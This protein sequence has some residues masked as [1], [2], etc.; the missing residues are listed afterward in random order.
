MYT[1]T[2]TQ[3]QIQTH[4][5][6]THVYTCIQAHT[7]TLCTHTHTLHNETYTHVTHPCSE[8]SRSPDGFRDSTLR[9]SLW[10]VLPIIRYLIT[11]LSNENNNLLDFVGNILLWILVSSGAK[12]GLGGGGGGAWPTQNF[13]YIF[14]F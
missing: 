13:Q 9:L 4:N 1:H 5:I 2:H 11:N 14:I 7:H 8:F 6:H 10:I 3:T 12:G